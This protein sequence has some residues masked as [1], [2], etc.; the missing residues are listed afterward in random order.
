M[1]WLLKLGEGAA[2]ALNLGGKA[3]KGAEEIGGSLG[4]AARTTEDVGGAASTAVRDAE[5]GAS[6]AARDAEAGGARN[7]ER[8]AAGGGGKT[9]SQLSRDAEDAGKAPKPPDK[10]PRSWSD[11]GAGAGKVIDPVASN[12]VKLTLG[13]TALDMLN[14]RLQAAEAGIG[15]GLH[16][17]G[18]D[19]K[20]ATRDLFESGENLVDHSAG[21]V[22]SEAEMARAKAASV[23]GGEGATLLTIAG[24]G[25]VAFAGYEGYRYFFHSS[26][27]RSGVNIT[28]RT[29]AAPV[30]VGQPVAPVPMGLPV[31]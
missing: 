25:L 30:P 24:L 29:P 13:L 18:E 21:W 19:A 5:G 31:Q 8:E 22:K 12:A 10:P 2:E 14:H 16:D 26:S 27:A 1:S 28:V 3:A 4:G 20:D 17:L 23:F 6:T 9:G 7:A 15:Q 11:I